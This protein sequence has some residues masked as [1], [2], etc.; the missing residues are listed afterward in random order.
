M[1]QTIEGLRKKKQSGD[2][3][4][5]VTAYDYPT[6]YAAEQ[7]GVDA[8]LVGDSLGMVVLGY[9]STL[10]VT[11]EVMIHHARAVC[12]AAKQTHVVVDMPF[13]TYQ[14]SPEEAVRNAGRLL[15][16]TGCQAVK[17]EGG[18][19]MAPT[20]RR[21]VQTG[22]PVMGHL[23]LTPQ[24]IHQLGGYRV[25]GRQL[26]D[27]RDLWEDALALVEAG[28][29][30]IVLECVPGELAEAMARRLPVP[31]IGIGAGAGCDGQVLVLH[32]LIGL[33]VGGHVPRF[34]KQFADVQGLIRQAVARYA[35]EVRLRQF[36]GQEHTY[37]LD[38]EVLQEWLAWIE[39]QSDADLPDGGQERP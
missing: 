5:M 32:D 26:E 12:R 25:Q 34:V 39:R 13:L 31:V 21:L 1:R 4:V 22:I 16:E 27:A 11:L 37:S 10:P 14:I 35:E 18:R 29:Y 24:S 28:V 9:E 15:Q 17:L 23:G 8:L 2:P 20:I 30:A 36:P 3:I 33:T 6:A 7:A 19:A 38:D